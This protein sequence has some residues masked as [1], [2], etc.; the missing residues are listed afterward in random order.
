MTRPKII[1]GVNTYHADSSACLIIDGEL[2]AAIEEERLNRVKHYAGFPTKAIKECLIIGNIKEEDITDIAF[3]TK[4]L[5]NLVP[6]GIHYLKNLSFKKNL[7]KKRFLKKKNID[8]IF[9]K[10][11]K[12]S[13]NT[14]FH[15]IEHHLAHI[16]SAFY[17]SK[18]KDANGL[19]IDGSG[20]FVSFA[21]AECKNNKITIKKKNY[22][23]DSLGIFYHAMTQF[24]GYK[25]YGDEYK[26]MGLA[27]YGRPIY[28]EK[29]LNNLFKN[30]KKIFC[31]NLDFF[32][33]HKKNFRYIADENLL[34]DEIFNSKLK[35]LFYDEIKE[36]NFHKNF[37]SSVQKIFEFFFKKIIDTIIKTNYS[38]NI[39]YSG[40][41]ALNSS[42]NKFLTDKNNFFENIFINCAP[43]DNGGALGAAFVVATNYNLNLTNIK[44][45]YLGKDFNKNQI[46]EILENDLYKKKFTYDCLKSD[47][48]LFNTASKYIADGKVI[49][50]FQG[51][52]EFGPRALGNRSILADPRNPNMKDII[53]KKIKRRESFR[54]FAPSVLAEFQSEWFEGN[55]FSPYMSSLMTVKKDKRKMIPAV[56]HFDNTARLQ[57]VNKEYNLRFSRLISAFYKLTNVPILLNTSFNEN[58]PIVF[59]PEE[60]LECIL[61]TEMDAIF[62]NNFLIKKI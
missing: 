62:I 39:V 9:K 14:K 44:S 35:H 40:G 41:C 61:R 30:D 5:S 3:N 50:W 24:L 54:P 10:N 28:F 37:A 18:F 34:I 48:E 53:N 58:E 19:S 31:L 51:K 59:K 42:A 46:K 60:A 8:K 4:P 2:I 16:A 6:K 43:G 26:I 7:A 11:L 12:L 27:A 36:E 1:L 38:K 21:Y 22:F 17:P 52:M 25:N 56:T 13:K 32:N 20:D 15:F 47:S 29:I 33:H 55:F 57:T 23:P 49:G 45:P